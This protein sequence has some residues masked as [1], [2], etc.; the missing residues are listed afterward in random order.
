MSKKYQKT[1]KSVPIAAAIRT[2][3]CSQ[4]GNLEN[5][6]GCYINVAW[7]VGGLIPYVH[8]N[9]RIWC[10]VWNRETKVITAEMVCV[11]CLGVFVG[12]LQEIS[13]IAIDPIVI[14]ERCTYHLSHDI[15]STGNQLS[16]K[17][18]FLHHQYQEN[19]PQYECD[20]AC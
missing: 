12:T 14:I 2:L 10:K 3:L 20:A 4:I 8:S 9:H 13:R 19:N 5:F 16:L 18:G 1:N 17:S 6:D 7:A 11:A 15:L